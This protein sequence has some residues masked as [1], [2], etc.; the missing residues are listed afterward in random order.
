MGNRDDQSEDGNDTTQASDS[1][2]RAEPTADAMT[3]EIALA[4]LENRDL[5]AETIAQISQNAAVMSRKVRFAVGVHSRTPR[6]IA[7]RLIREFYTFDLMR[8]S[9]LPAVAADLKRLAD[10]LL[11][12]RLAGITLGERISL[13]RKSSGNV[14]GA[15]LH[16]KDARVWQAALENPR[17]VEAALVK[18][19]VRPGASPAFIQKVCQHGKW[20]VR[21]EVQIALLRN[22][23]TPL[24]RA[25]E[26]A[27]RLSPAR[28][29]D[30]LH[31]S[32]LPERTKEYLRKEKRKGSRTQE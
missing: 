21:P 7:L 14:A 15:L 16:D 30:I 20:S 31:V 5:S 11:V 26:F 10:D 27:A 4:L 19:V 17:L 18:G 3:E 8:A 6:R 22:E 1:S 2:S 13:A 9:L 23:Y 25:V 29:R 32:K 24:A 28:L 12:S